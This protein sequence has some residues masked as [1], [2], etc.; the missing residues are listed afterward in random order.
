MLLGYT[1]PENFRR[2]YL[3]VNVSDFW[4]RWHISL[5]TWLRDYLYIP[6][7]GNRTH[8][9]RNLMLTMTLGGLWH[10]ASTTY[11]VWGA[12]QG[13]YLTLFWSIRG[14]RDKPQF[15]GVAGSVV[16]VPSWAVTFALI[17]VGWVFFRATNT[18][19]ALVMLTSM[20]GAHA[21][22]DAVLLP[23]QR[24]LVALIAAGTLS[25]EAVREWQE[26]RVLSGEP[27]RPATATPWRGW[28]GELRP[29][30][31]LALFLLAVLLQPSDAGRFI[32]F[33]F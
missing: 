23:T 26:R 22:V 1:V 16:A 13:L 17:C 12:L 11:L 25:L 30:G 31:Y 14:R 28:A 27:A 21:G 4:R 15:T 6:L 33:Q 20:L 10:G 19:H 18:S 8:R 7:G 3:A 2:P 5:S 24:L 29:L 9:K 32:Y